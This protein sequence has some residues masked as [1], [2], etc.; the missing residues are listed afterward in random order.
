MLGTSVDKKNL[1]ENPAISVGAWDEMVASAFQTEV[2]NSP[3]AKQPLTGEYIAE[4]L[5]DEFGD[6]RIELLAGEN[7]YESAIDFAVTNGIITRSQ[8][9]SEFSQEAA[10]RALTVAMELYSSDV[11]YPNYDETIYKENVVK[12]FDWDIVNGDEE[13]NSIEVKTTGAEP[14]VGEI[15][16]LHDEN[17][18]AKARKVVSSQKKDNGAYVLE[19]ER[20]K[21]LSEIADVISF[22]GTAD[23]SE[24]IEGQITQ[25]AS[26]IPLAHTASA[27]LPMPTMIAGNFWEG[28][29]DLTDKWFGINI[30]DSGKKTDITIGLAIEI[31]G[32][33]KMGMASIVKKDGVETEFGINEDG[34][35]SGSIS[36]ED[37]ELEFEEGEE[38]EDDDDKDVEIETKSRIEGT[39]SLNDFRVA[40]KGFF[41]TTDWLD[42]DNYFDVL[43]D[44]DVEFNLA[45]KGEF[46]GKFKIS[47][48]IECRIPITAGTVA[49]ELVPYLVVTAEGEISLTWE[50]EGIKTGMNVSVEDGLKTRFD[51]TDKKFK[52]EANIEIQTGIATEV[53]ISFCEFDLIDP[54]LEI[55]PL[56]VSG[57]I[58]PKNEGFEDYP[59]CMELGIR[60]VDVSLSVCYGNDSATYHILHFINKNMDWEFTLIDSEDSPIYKAQAHVEL[61]ENGKP[62]KVDECTRVKPDP[63]G[64]AIE[65]VMGDAV[66]DAINKA[67]DEANSFFESFIN[68]MIEDFLFENC[69]DLY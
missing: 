31:D 11:M 4:T 57:S 65:D 62:H 6:D 52:A 56:T 69:G 63:I 37:V 2:A 15:L 41:V 66:D 18:I 17:G 19:L 44:T 12:A 46:E 54:G 50:L 43:V 35:L 68:D 38:D 30:K 32:E 5:M 1:K 55:L 20:V 7:G 61:D 9:D 22:S 58:L 48:A 36:F 27:S 14:K 10:N 47:D 45:L 8:I 34:E 29:D 33:G 28:L 42:K 49:V 13:F 60:G 3:N 40:A 53:A 67:E 26:I 21:E 23:F 64:D 39:V 51:I 59:P 16:L 25:S 24:D